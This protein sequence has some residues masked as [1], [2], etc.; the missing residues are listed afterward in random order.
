MVMELLPYQASL[1]IGHNRRSFNKIIFF[2]KKLI[3]N[4]NSRIS[5]SFQGMADLSPFII[6]KNNFCQ[7]NMFH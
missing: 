5:T 1:K 4:K 3:F 2:I 6:N 7:R